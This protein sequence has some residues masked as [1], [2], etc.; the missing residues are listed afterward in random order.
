[1]AK[2]SGR[3]TRAQKE[4]ANPGGVPKTSK[5]AE[6]KK[7]RAKGPKSAFAQAAPS[8]EARVERN[9]SRRQRVAKPANLDL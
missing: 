2:S 3:L 8:N 7:A 9:R 6:K 4:A 1:M 5:Y